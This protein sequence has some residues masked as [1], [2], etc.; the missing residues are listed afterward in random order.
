MITTQKLGA[1]IAIAVLSVVFLLSF[2]KL[3][4]AALGTS[5]LP[6]TPFHLQS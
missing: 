6:E 3:S 4:E 2:P 1:W 5:R